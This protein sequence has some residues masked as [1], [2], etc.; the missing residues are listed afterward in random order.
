MP[1]SSVTRPIFTLFSRQ[2][3]GL[4]EDVKETLLRVQQRTP[5]TLKEID[6]DDPQQ[7]QWLRKYMYEVPVVHRDDVLVGKHRVTEQQVEQ[8]LKDANAK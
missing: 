7:K 4:C 1:P 5:F 8:W 3:C 6:I 2:Y